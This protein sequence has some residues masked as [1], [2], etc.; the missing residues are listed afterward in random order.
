MPL[1]FADFRKSE[2]VWLLRA[3]VLGLALIYSALWLSGCASMTEAR[4]E[5]RITAELPRV[6]GPAA[7]YQVNV[8]GARDNGEIADIRRLHVIGTRVEREKSPVLDRI[9][10]TMSDIVFDRK[11]KRL[12]SL[13][14][15]DANVRV[16]PS[17]LAAFLDARP[18]LDNVIVTLYPPYEITIETQFAIAGFALPRVTSA[19][20]R[21]R[22]VVNDGK[23]AMEVVDLRVAGFPVGTIPT[24]IVER[25]INPLVDLSAPPAAARVTSVQVM[26]DSVLLTA[27]NALP[28][29]QSRTASGDALASR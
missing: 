27:S 28:P 11:E 1:R 9:E 12:L 29:S 2:V 8:Q 19:K 14:T 15:A 18:G 26:S 21:G 23:L 10:V 13:G 22:L 25:L 16:L 24:I 7:R 20:I 5:Q 17:D 6:V 4:V 3:C